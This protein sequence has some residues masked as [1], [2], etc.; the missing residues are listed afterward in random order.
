[1]IKEPSTRPV[2]ELHYSSLTYSTVRKICEKGLVSLPVQ[3]NETYLNTMPTAVARD[4][5]EYADLCEMGG[6]DNE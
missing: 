1:M 2:K 4:L 5:T 6:L 3:T